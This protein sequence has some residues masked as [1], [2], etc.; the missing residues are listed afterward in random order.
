MRLYEININSLW[1]VAAEDEME[2]LSILR[3]ELFDREV[4]EEEMDS[5]ME[6][7]ELSELEQEEAELIDVL[8]VD[9]LWTFYKARF[10]SGLIYTDYYAED[11]DDELPYSDE[12]PADW[13]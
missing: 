6:E 2:A 8:D 9:T 7:L 10:D 1:W 3:G 11:E 13:L 4:S 12:F 5:V